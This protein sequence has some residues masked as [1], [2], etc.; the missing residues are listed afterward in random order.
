MKT[1]VEK[2]LGWLAKMIVRKYRPEV[3]GVTGSLGKT[4]VKDIT[5]GILR[6]SFSV[7]GN[8]SSYNNELGVPL[9]IVGVKSPGKS[10]VGWFLIFCQAIKLLFLRDENY[11][12]ILVLEM[13]ANRPGDLEKLV[14][15]APCHVGLVTSVS[16]AHLKFFKTVKKVSQEK[17]LI[18]SHLKKTDYAILNRD[19]AEV[20]E[21]GK[22]TDADVISFGFHPSADVRTSDVTIK[23]KDNDKQRPEGL[24]FKVI[25]QGNIVPMYLSGIIG[26][27]SVYRASAAIAVALIFGMNLVEISNALRDVV[28]PPGRMR[29]IPGIKDTLLVDDS[30]NASPLAVKAA[31]ETLSLIPI[32]GNGERYVVLGDMLE[33]GAQTENS[34]REVGLRVAELGIDFLITVG[35]AMKG[36]AAAAKEAGMPENSVA[37]FNTAEEAGRFLQEKIQTGDLILI[38]GSRAMHMEKV[39]KEVM[40]E[41]D[42]AGE[43]LVT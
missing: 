42:K 11:P 21:M 3:V 15:I 24:F 31:M 40:A 32:Q 19:D 13:A 17:R 4:S 8:H 1:I 12:E 43:L 23:F 6:H 35:E 18:V 25:Y 38:K 7:R 33:L 39:V 22:K 10:F 26:E 20:Y 29:L 34:H 2:L 16:P 36:A 28:M 9:T 14:K 41:P 37:S 27:H 5:V 30:Y